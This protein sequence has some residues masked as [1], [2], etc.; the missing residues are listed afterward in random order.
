MSKIT[1]DETEYSQWQET[2]NCLSQ[3]VADLNQELNRVT[4][5]NNNN[6]KEIV[7]LK[8][9]IKNITGMSL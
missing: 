4:K 9:S 1:I 6:V 5:I 2:I 8:Q 7:E 3:L